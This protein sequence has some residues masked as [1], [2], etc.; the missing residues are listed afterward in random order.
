MDKL[1]NVTIVEKSINAAIR[2]I[3]GIIADKGL[4]TR[5]QVS[6][7]IIRHSSKDIQLSVEQG[8]EYRLRN[9][10]PIYI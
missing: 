4:V 2:H 7:A 1:D 6:K 8:V 5:G 9:R 10:G 3:D